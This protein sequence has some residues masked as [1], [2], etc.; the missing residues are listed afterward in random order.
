MPDQEH[1]PTDEHA[2]AA[3]S[4]GPETAEAGAAGE[5]TEQASSEQVFCAVSKQMV[6][7]EETIE[8]ERKPGEVLRIH[9]RY[10]KYED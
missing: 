9:R 1:S 8:I 10:K 7:K 3:T 6:P 4:P 2:S 5:G